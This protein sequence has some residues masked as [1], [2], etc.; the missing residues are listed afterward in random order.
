MYPDAI[1]DREVLVEMVQELN[2]NRLPKLSA[3]GSKADLVARIAEAIPETAEQAE[4]Q[5]GVTVERHTTDELEAMKVSEL[6]ALIGLMNGFRAGLLPT[7]GSRH[8]LAD[9]LREN[10]KPVT[11]WS[12]VQEEWAETVA[13]RIVLTQDEWDQLHAM[14]DAVMAHPVASKLLTSVPGT[15]E[16]SVYWN[17]PITG[18]L[19]RCRPDYWRNDGI[20]VDLKTT[21]DAS[22]DE[23]SRSVAKWRY[24]VQAPY[25]LDG[26]AQAIQQAGLDLGVPRHFL[27][28]VVEKKPPY[29]VAVYQLD[30]DSMELGRQQYRQDLDLYHRCRQAGE[31]PGYSDS[32]QEIGV[33]Q[34]YLVRNGGGA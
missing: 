4:A 23:F 28:L 11:L 5:T 29:G 21:D 26:C 18:E 8:Q 27:F 7:S 33:P 3:T 16:Q 6:K 9:L 13:G 31:W 32:I 20:L 12:D 22:L 17:D 25:Y 34:W 1:E 2:A 19:C 30:A 14:R 10:G 24:H 15:A